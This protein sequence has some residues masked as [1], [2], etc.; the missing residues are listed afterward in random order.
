MSLKYTVVLFLA[1]QV[2]RSHY[3]RTITGLK[4]GEEKSYE[5]SKQCLV[6]ITSCL[7]VFSVMEVVLYFIYLTYVSTTK[8]YRKSK[9]IIEYFIVSSMDKDTPEKRAGTRSK[10]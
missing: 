4:D 7:C 8:I 10:R 6:A 1:Y 5:N 9:I 3:T 2:K